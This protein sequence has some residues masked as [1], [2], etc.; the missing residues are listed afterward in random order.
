MRIRFEGASRQVGRSQFE[1]DTEEMTI[2]LDA[3]MARDEEKV[4]LKPTRRPDAIILSHAHLDHSGF[5]PSY[6]QNQRMPWLATF[7]TLPITGILWPDSIKVMRS[8]KESPPITEKEIKTC[9]RHCVALPMHE[10]YEF[11]DGTTA[12]LHDAGHILGSAQ[13][14]L[15]K[16]DKSLLYTG[17]YNS[18]PTRNHAPAETPAKGVSGLIIESTYS[19]RDHPPRQDV[20]RAFITAVKQAT[21]SG[22]AL[23]P[24]FALGRTQE[25]LQVL[26]AA[27]IRAPI[28]VDG[29]GTDV[30]A[31]YEEYTAFVRD[32]VALERAIERARPIENSSQRRAVAEGKGNVIITTAGMLE[33]G[34]VL[35]YM[36]K[37]NAAGRGAVLLTGYQ[38]EET[39]GR[40]LVDSKLVKYNGKI[41][42]VSLPVKQFDFSAHSGK[43]ESFEYVR[44]VNPEK[45]FCV[46]G[47]ETVCQTFA[48]KLR[49]EGFDAYA[50]KIGEEHAL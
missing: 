32:H 10:K 38:V 46:H 30:N 42:K 29:M 34:P 12:E 11:Y 25:I 31:V 49:E 7:P 50:P 47:D 4:P 5:L 26:D 35:S 44:A 48:E 45:V 16:G 22:N 20:E 24:C 15:E 18:S 36:D 28:W 39:N 40:R 13:V 37:M 9:V 27:G 33:G 6:Y 19:D 1:V 3:G 2:L 41:L 43:T 17:D 8:R 14:L 21:E 23:V